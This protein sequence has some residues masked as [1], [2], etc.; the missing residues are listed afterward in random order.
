MS[1]Q[2]KARKIKELREARVLAIRREW[3]ATCLKDRAQAENDFHR[4]NHELSIIT[5]GKQ[6]V[7]GP[8]KVSKKNQSF[9]LK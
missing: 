7:R 9:I 3:D 5:N 1:I 8:L 4:I 2:E 6:G